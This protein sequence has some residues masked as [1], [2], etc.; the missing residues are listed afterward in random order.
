MVEPQQFRFNPETAATNSFMHGS[1]GP[2]ADGLLAR[3]LEESRA[4]RSRLEQAGVDVIAVDGRHAHETP[5]AV[6][7]NNWFSTHEPGTLVLYPM[8]ARNRALERRP[9]V[10]TMLR[11]RFGARDLIDLTFFEKRGRFLEGT[12]SVVLDRKNAIAYA[13]LS[14][15]T[16]PE[17]LKELAGQLGFDVLEF[18]LA[19]AGGREIYHTNVMLS[20]GESLAVACLDAVPDRRARDALRGRL[21]ECGKTV[22]DI[23]FEQLTRFCGNVLELRGRDGHRLWA[24]SESARAHFTP[25]QLQAIASDGELVSSAI[26]S[27]ERV[28]GGSVRCMIA[29]LFLTETALRESINGT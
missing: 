13:G 16:H 7:P 18:P 10:V 3:A 12:G 6:F 26:P 5:D 25:G 20:V 1:A 22:I 28:G 17:P 23:S 19:D 4:L 14:S 15:R 8:A 21:N 2:L 11:E 9:D 27:L 24:M 29:E